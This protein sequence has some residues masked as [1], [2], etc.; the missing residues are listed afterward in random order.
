MAGASD[1]LGEAA[2]IPRPPPVAREAVE[3]GLV[4]FETR[5]LASKAPE[6]F[7]RAFEKT[8]GGADASSPDDGVVL[9]TAGYARV[10]TSSLP[11]SLGQQGFLECL[12]Q[13]APPLH[14]PDRLRK[15][16]RM[17]RCSLGDAAGGEA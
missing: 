5:L 13:E 1:A 7:V 12:Y 15:P 14:S 3:R 17:S 9:S 16:P 6:L 2:N 10:A 4:S 11:L 8:P